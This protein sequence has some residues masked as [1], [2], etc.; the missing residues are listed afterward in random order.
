MV[1]NTSQSPS[2]R[3][4][5]WNLFLQV[6]AVI[7][8]LGAL[9]IAYQQYVKPNIDFIERNQVIQP[10]PIVTPSLSASSTPI[11]SVNPTPKKPGAGIESSAPD[12]LDCEEVDEEGN[13]V[14]DEDGNQIPWPCPDE[15][16]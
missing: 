12:E 9:I 14:L 15:E 1:H 5:K 7:I 10:I 4:E 11:P 3:Y 16:S 8:G 6:L 2:S 13:P